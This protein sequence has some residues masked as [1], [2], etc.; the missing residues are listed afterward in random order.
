MSETSDERFRRRQL[1]AF[2]SLSRFSLSEARISAAFR[3]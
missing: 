3:P 1:E 2:D